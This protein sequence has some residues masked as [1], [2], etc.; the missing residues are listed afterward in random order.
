[1]VLPSLD[2]A[3]VAPEPV[4]GGELSLDVNGR[5]LRREVLD[6]ASFPI[7]TNSRGV[8]ANPVV[9][10]IEGDNGRLSAEAAWKRSLITEGGLVVTP[11]LAFRGDAGYD[12]ASDASIAAINQMAADDRIN[13]AAD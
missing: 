9:P 6:S 10:G 13:A 12:N 8:R 7:R 4:A 11:L 3:Y 2:Y 1:W 5:A